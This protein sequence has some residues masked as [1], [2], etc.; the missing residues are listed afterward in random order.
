MPGPVRQAAVQRQ[1]GL[2]S[3]EGPQSRGCERKEGEGEG[4]PEALVVS[5]WWLLQ[6]SIPGGKGKQGRQAVRGGGFSFVL[7]LEAE[8]LCHRNVD[9]SVAGPG[10]SMWSPCAMHWY[11]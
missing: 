4:E 11:P 9:H 6:Q 7:R 5:R 8:L 2:L 1:S 10:D 3:L